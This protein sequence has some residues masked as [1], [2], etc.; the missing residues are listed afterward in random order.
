MN[1]R[2]IY[3]ILFAVILLLIVVS[4]ILFAFSRTSKEFTVSFYY[5][6]A[7][8]NN[9]DTE[10]RIISRTEDTTNAE[11]FDTVISEL[12]SGPK[13]NLSLVNTLADTEILSADLDEAKKTAYVELSDGFSEK[14]SIDRLFIK[15]SIVYTLTALGFI[16]EV[17]ITSGGQ[18]VSETSLNRKNFIL[19]PD[20]ASEKINYQSITLYFA[21]GSMTYLQGEQRLLEVKQSLDTEYQLV[22]LLLGGPESSSLVCPIPS[23]TK[24]INTTTENGICYVNLSSAFLNKANGGISTLQ[25]YSIVNS[26]TSLDSV[27]SVQLYIEGQK[28]TDALTEVDIS[29]EL[30]RNEE[31]IKTS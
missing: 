23:G 12:E 5:K 3:I 31:L 13:V 10:A 29:T 26:L 27:S 7:A 1:R 21:D 4:C 22:E 6:N 17:V 14:S 2:K 8:G 11:L 28:V 19:N 20:I 24:L 25:V 9:L 18:A 16:D 15:G 30:E